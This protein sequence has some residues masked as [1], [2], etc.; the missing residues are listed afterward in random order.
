MTDTTTQEHTSIA[1]QI[2]DLETGWYSVPYLKRLL[3]IDTKPRRIE[4][5]ALFGRLSWHHII[6]PA[7]VH[8]AD[9]YT[10]RCWYLDVPAIRLYLDDLE[11]RADY[12]ASEWQFAHTRRDGRVR[13]GHETHADALVEADR[14]TPSDPER[15]Q[16]LC[17]RCPECSDWHV[18]TFVPK[19]FAE[20]HAAFE[21]TS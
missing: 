17:Y 18:S 19:E 8:H 13:T 3:N 14:L 21:V 7:D 4:F 1:S 9:E 16:P 15:P 2:A 20:L 10:V 12:D 11:R 5:N 6:R